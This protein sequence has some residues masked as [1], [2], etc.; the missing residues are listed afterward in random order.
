M[1]LASM[2]A[3]ERFSD[4]PVS[5]CPI[6][7]AIL[8]AHNDMVDDSRRGDLYRYAAEAVGTRG[9]FE[10]QLT[11]AAAA[12]TWAR[13]RH[14]RR[15][16]SIRGRLRPLAVEPAPDHGPD[17]IARYVIRS[18]GRDGHGHEQILGLLDH[19]IELSR[20]LAPLPE[21]ARSESAPLREPVR[22]ESAPLPE[23]LTALELFE[24]DGE[25]IEHCGRREQLL[26]GELA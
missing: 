4:H 14:V 9:D 5:V 21:P 23:P 19:L 24:Q 6:V 25:P 16:S 8:R 10:L 15:R 11:R 3:G 20:E 13:L 18:V 1:E 22:R 17:Q 26:I 2:L 7:G 12:I